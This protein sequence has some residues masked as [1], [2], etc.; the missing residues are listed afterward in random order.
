[1]YS[2]V[3]N[4]T[5]HVVFKGMRSYSLLKTISDECVSELNGFR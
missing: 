4:C 3:S 5:I 1:M 2:V